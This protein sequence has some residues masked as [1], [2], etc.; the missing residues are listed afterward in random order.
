MKD[1]GDPQWAHP[2]WKKTL[3]WLSAGSVPAV[4]TKGESYDYQ[5]IYQYTRL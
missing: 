3:T 1:S 5:S 4:P 2:G